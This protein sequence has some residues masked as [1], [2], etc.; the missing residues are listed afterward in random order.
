[1]YQCKSQL[2]SGLF[3]NGEREALWIY[4]S[5]IFSGWQVVHYSVIKY[6]TPSFCMTGSNI[7]QLTPGK[8]ARGF[9]LHL[10]SFLVTSWIGAA[11]AT[12]AKRSLVEDRFALSCITL[13]MLSQLEG[14]GW[15]RTIGSWVNNSDQQD[16]WSLGGGS[17][18]LRRCDVVSRFC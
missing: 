16:S 5:P 1:M 7:L 12:C 17:T 18:R 4:L 10:L 15:T 13:K 9:N 6:H 2:E 11:H 3:E 8:G 14:E